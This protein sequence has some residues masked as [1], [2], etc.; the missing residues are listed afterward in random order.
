MKYQKDR[1]TMKDNT[2]ITENNQILFITFISNCVVLFHMHICRYKVNCRSV[3]LS[4]NSLNGR[5]SS[6][7]FRTG[8]FRHATNL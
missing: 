2:L 5:H 8:N 7:F 4:E 1:K 3:A 6:E